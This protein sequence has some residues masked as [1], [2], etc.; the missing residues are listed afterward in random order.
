MM[1]HRKTKIHKSIGLDTIIDIRKDSPTYCEHIQVE[2]TDNN[3]TMLYV[4]EGFAH[5]F[6]TL[7][8]DC[9]VFYQVSQF[10][11]PGKESGIRWND[12]LFGINW[13]TDSPV[14]S[15]KDA[16]HPDWVR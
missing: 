7:Q 13:P 6:I 12:P 11:T 14:L 9:Q 2:L 1:Y 16:V 8:E 3:N 5:G 15:D 10:Y 4:P